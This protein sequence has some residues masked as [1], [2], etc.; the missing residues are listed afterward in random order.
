MSSLMSRINMNIWALVHR[1][2]YQSL[3]SGHSRRIFE[4]SRATMYPRKMSRSYQ[5]T[6]RNPDGTNFNR[7]ALLVIRTVKDTT[8][9]ER[10]PIKQ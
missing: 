8:Q 4:I 3:Y 2:G 5:L 6:G 10:A 9:R 1:F 7:A